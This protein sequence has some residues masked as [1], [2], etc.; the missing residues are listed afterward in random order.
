MYNLYAI[1]GQKPGDKG[2]IFIQSQE[3]FDKD[4]PPVR[5][6]E[7]QRDSLVN[8]FTE[9]E[10]VTTH[11]LLEE[12]EESE[13]ESG[14]I[15]ER[16]SGNLISKKLN[17]TFGSATPSKEKHHGL[18]KNN[19]TFWSSGVEKE[20]KQINVPHLPRNNS[21]SRKGKE[22]VQV[23]QPLYKQ[24]GRPTNEIPAEHKKKIFQL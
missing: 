19:F 18:L 2:Q 23:K 9:L 14:G 11:S 16:P 5:L 6:S 15:D 4:L 24:L 21:P 3:G 1:P 20:Q 17:P 13:E 22:P 10:R 12:I 8:D 7:H